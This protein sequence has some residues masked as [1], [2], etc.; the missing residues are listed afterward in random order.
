M[1]KAAAA[2]GTPRNACLF[3]ISLLS[4]F[5]ML[6]KLF[7]T[8]ENVLLYCVGFISFMALIANTLYFHNNFQMIFCV[9]PFG[10]ALG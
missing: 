7:G 4:I 2:A 3:A 5:Y 10:A 1:K 6:V 9:M 8:T